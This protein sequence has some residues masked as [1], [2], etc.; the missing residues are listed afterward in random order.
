M[1]SIRDTVFDALCCQND[2]VGDVA[3]QRPLKP[4]AEEDHAAI[5]CG[6]QVQLRNV[7]EIEIRN[8]I[9][10]QQMFH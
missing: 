8:I 7:I 2:E 3:L 1:V 9:N 5:I 4:P 6:L 10:P